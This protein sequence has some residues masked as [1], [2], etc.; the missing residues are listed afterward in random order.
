MS[1]L[2]AMVGL[3]R[4]GKSTICRNT[5]LPQG[6]AIVNPDNFRLAIH[7]QRYVS[8][9]EPFVWACVNAAVDALLLSGNKVV[10]DATNLQ[11]DRRATWARRGAR[12]VV[13]DT[14]KEECIRRAQVE[15]DDYIIP[16]IERMAMY[17]DSIDDMEGLTIE[18]V[19][20]W[21]AKDESA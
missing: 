21:E 17:N 18:A 5:Y 6:Y 8:Q 20:K 16:V 4:S 2:L 15:N 9:A 10:V 1:D 13:V 11:S 7:G 12:F 19:H 3:P 14:P